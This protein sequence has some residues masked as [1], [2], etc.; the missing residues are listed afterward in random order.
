MTKTTVFAGVIGFL[1]GVVTCAAIMK[2]AN[3]VSESNFREKPHHD[4]VPV[5]ATEYAEEDS[6]SE[7]VVV[8]DASKKADDER[9]T[10]VTDYSKFFQKPEPMTAN[11]GHVLTEEERMDILNKE[12]LEAEEK[13][14]EKHGHE[15]NPITAEEFDSD[16]PEVLYP[17]QTLYFYPANDDHED[18]LVDE[19]DEELDPAV[20]YVGEK[21]F[22]FRFHLVNEDDEDVV[23]IRNNPKEI[24]YMVICRPG[25]PEDY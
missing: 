21:F 18:L 12:R 16:F 14:K 5:P 6:T 15:I 10:H 11:D 19:D 13:Y 22:K 20:E 2:I 17:R 7:E 9:D 3:G 25:S 23:Y 24:D 4:P 1:A 8:S